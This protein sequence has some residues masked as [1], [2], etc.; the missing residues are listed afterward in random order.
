MRLYNCELVMSTMNLRQRGK[1]SET[2]I[3]VD[4]A[5][6]F[7]QI[8][9]TSS[10]LNASKRSGANDFRGR[11]KCLENMGKYFVSGR[12]SSGPQGSRE[13]RETVLCGP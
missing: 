2:Q 6:A 1:I 3:T 10:F 9:G 5:W 11:T 8:Q 7:E 13:E 12:T 4:S